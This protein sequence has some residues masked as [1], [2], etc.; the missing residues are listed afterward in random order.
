MQIVITRV[1]T[2]LDRDRSNKPGM[3]TGT[4][5]FSDFWTK[6]LQRETFHLILAYNLFKS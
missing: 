1:S 2:V 4:A 3:R 5:V 6:V